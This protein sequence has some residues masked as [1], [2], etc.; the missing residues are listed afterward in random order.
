MDK[1]AQ[2][3]FPPCYYT[4]NTHTHTYSDIYCSSQLV[5]IECYSESDLDLILGIVEANLSV[6]L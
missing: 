1:N 2:L 6:I 4:T 3:A 5:A